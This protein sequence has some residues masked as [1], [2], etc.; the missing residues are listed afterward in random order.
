MSALSSLDLP[1]ELA[2]FAILAGCVLAALVVG[3]ALGVWWHA[4][5]VARA[6]GASTLTA[7]EARR[8]AA[9]AITT[10]RRATGGA[11]ATGLRAVVWDGRRRRL[12][13]LAGRHWTIGSDLGCTIVVHGEG[14]APLHARL[15]VAG[16]GLTVTDLESTSGT[17]IGPLGRP[18]TPGVPVPVAE[19]EVVQL[20]LTVK[21]MLERA[22]A[23][24]EALA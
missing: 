21:L 24:P 4:R 16:D 20:G 23:A 5:R 7:T 17:L 11:G 9:A 12:I 14:V 3:C 22:V 13:P 2:V 15:S 6:D 1:P 10:A 8:R 19:G 18:L